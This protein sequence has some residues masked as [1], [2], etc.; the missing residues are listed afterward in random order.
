MD[1][2]LVSA[3]VSAIKAS[4]DI[5]K[6]ALSIRDANLLSLE[7]ARMNEQLLRAQDALFRHNSQ[8]L[9]LQQ[10]LMEKN[11]ALR[12]AQETIAERARYRLTEV[13]DGN[14]VYRSTVL[15]MGDEA[16]PKDR[17]HYLCQPCF[18][19]GRTVVLQY[20]FTESWGKGFNCPVCKLRVN[21][22]RDFQ[23]GQG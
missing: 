13:S 17:P 16:A 19:S 10:D 4:S 6:A 11:E 21:L 3:A 14:W 9:E 2:S 8:L 5:G 23:P 18:D 20:S 12:K 22:R 1:F 7:V 15:T